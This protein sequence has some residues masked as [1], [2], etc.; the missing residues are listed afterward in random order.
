MGIW[1]NAFKIPA[2]RE[3]APEEKELLDALAEKARGRAM[4]DLAAMALESTRPLH[5][6]GSQGIVFLS[7]M[8]SMILNKEEVSR[9]AEILENPA[10]VNYL[11][12]RLGADPGKKA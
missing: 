10:A 7:P 8:L 6:L 4:G 9:Y 5:H 12:E 3:V 1:D 2:P 11:V